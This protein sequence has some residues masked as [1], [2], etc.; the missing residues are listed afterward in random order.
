MASPSS[1]IIGEGAA[2]FTDST[3]MILDVLDKQV[4]T[5]PGSQQTTKERPNKDDQ[6]VIDHN[7]QGI[8][9]ETSTQRLS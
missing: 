6:K 5:S 7:T 1:D 8:G 9:P 2:T 3:E 4:I